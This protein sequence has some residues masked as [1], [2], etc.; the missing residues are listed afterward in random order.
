ME[1]RVASTAFPGFTDIHAHPAMNAFLWGRDLRKHYMSGRTFNPL[2]S[3][4]DFKMLEK[5]GVKVLW[6]S[7][8]IPESNYFRCPIMRLVA[9]PFRN[10]RL[11]M[12][13]NAWECLVRMKDMM[14]EQVASAD[15]FEVAHTNAELDAV[16]E[17]GKT[18]IV[19]TV[20]GGHVLGAGL[21]DDDLDGRLARVDELAG[22]G[23]ASLTIT[24]LFPNELAGHANGIPPHQQRIVFCKIDPEVEPER[25]L[26]EIGQEVVKR[27]VERR[28]VPDVT[29][30]TPTARG[31]IYEL[32]GTDIPLV[33]SHTGVTSMNDE[34]LNVGESDASA[35]AASGG[36]VGVIFMPFWLA[37]AHP[38]DGLDAIWKTMETI[39]EWTGSWENVAI[40]TDFDGFTDPPDDC[41]DASKL[42][43]IRELLDRHGVAE[44]DAD[45]ILG[46]NARRVLAS[47]W[48]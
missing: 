10:G 29:H 47:G 30:C 13:L 44:A 39:R 22:W 19:H 4:S 14:E 37:K 45:A 23:V 7:L 41:Q 2:A 12:K 32:V 11:L 31:E 20:E 40:G 8:H 15:R 24:H 33:A 17:A 46:G 3:L 1:G 25:G 21:D 5:G 43:V 9:Q 38:K 28:I 42:P 6:S 26:T 35:I 16:L 36:V 18:A 27:M 34:D 48:T